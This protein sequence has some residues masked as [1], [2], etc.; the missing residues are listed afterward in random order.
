[1]VMAERKAS[2]QSS[3]RQNSIVTFLESS[4]LVSASE[5]HGH[6]RGGFR[7][8]CG[9]RRFRGGGS[10]IG[11][12]GDKKCDY[13]HDINHAKPYC[14]V[15]YGKSNYVNQVIGGGTQ[16]QLL[17]LSLGTQLLVLVLMMH[18]L[19]NLASLFNN[20]ALHCALLLNLA[21]L[22]IELPSSSVAT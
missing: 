6:S 1:M 4:I 7:G 18:S 17:L 14:W 16:P 12:N 19:H 22:F 15:R 10:C 5:G 3:L 11:S 9:G 13:C 8:S 2:L 21:S 20:C